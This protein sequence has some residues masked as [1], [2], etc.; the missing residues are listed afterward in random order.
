MAN[1]VF[2]YDDFFVNFNMLKIRISYPRAVTANYQQV[3]QKYIN[4]VFILKI[5]P[6]IIQTHLKFHSNHF[7]FYSSTVAS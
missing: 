2:I 1:T 5:I 7:S 3:F 6:T 4:A